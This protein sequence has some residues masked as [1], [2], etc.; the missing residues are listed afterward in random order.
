MRRTNRKAFTLVEAAIAGALMV[1]LLS[2]LAVAASGARRGESLAS[3]HLGLMES[4]ALAMHQLRTDLR[5]VSFV[6]GK[7][8]AGTSIAISRDYKAIALRRSSHAVI[9]GAAAGSFFIRVEYRLIPSDHRADRYHIVRIESTSSGAPL[10]G[11]RT[12]REERI[13][14]SFTVSDASFLYKEDDAK[15]IRTLHVGLRVTSDG[16][17]LPGWGPFRE[18]ELVLTNVLS[19][20]RPEAPFA[21]PTMWAQPVTVQAEKPPGDVLAPVARDAG[22]LTQPEAL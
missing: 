18:K 10:P 5:Q 3:L 2:A 20:L 7:P 21:Y 15:D 16:G 9:G 8:V 1:S 22:V 14:R 19:V 11:K 13:F 4:V 12:S 6:A 17:T